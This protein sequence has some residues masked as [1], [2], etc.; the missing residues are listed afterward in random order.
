MEKDKQLE[1][2]S[3]QRVHELFLLLTYLPPTP[4]SLRFVRRKTKVFFFFFFFFVTQKF[5]LNLFFP[6]TV[7]CVFHDEWTHFGSNC[8]RALLVD[9][10]E[11]GFVR[12]SRFGLET[13]NALDAATRTL[14][15]ER[16][17]FSTKKLKPKKKSQFFVNDFL[18]RSK[19][20]FCEV[21]MA[22]VDP[23]LLFSW[24]KNSNPKK[25]KKKKKKQAANFCLLFSG[26]H[27][28]ESYCWCTRGRHVFDKHPHSWFFLCFR[29]FFFFFFFW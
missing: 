11:L 12:R 19:R 6:Q 3:P 4:E 5:F 10:D 24:N 7:V 8:L 9:P 25:K 28:V 26:N 29:F 21:F 18:Q 1:M 13:Q 14:I 27:I 20:A 22:D 2:L 17:L 23:K 15:C 16:F